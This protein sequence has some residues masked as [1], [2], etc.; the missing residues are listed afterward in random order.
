MQTAAVELGEDTDHA[1]ESAALVREAL[2]KCD[3]PLEQGGLEALTTVENF[4]DVW[5]LPANAARR[6]RFLSLLAGEPETMERVLGLAPREGAAGRVALGLLNRLAQDAAAGPLLLPRLSRVLQE[7]QRAAA[8]QSRLMWLETSGS[9]LQHSSDPLPDDFSVFLGA[10][11][12]AAAAA[13]GAAAAEEEAAVCAEL[14]GL[15][16]AQLLARRGAAGAAERQVLRALAAGRGEWRC[17]RA[18]EGLALLLLEARPRGRSGGPSDEEAAAAR[19]MRAGAER[20]W[21]QCGL[22]LAAVFPGEPA[23]R[24]C[25]AAGR[26]SHCGGC[27]AV[28]YCSAACQKSDWAHHKPECRAKR[29][30]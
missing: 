25:G 10:C 30:P 28:H 21:R 16:A 27:R 4:L 7:T 13:T 6:P 12:A 29:Q 15:L 1:G 24:G 14:A 8:G 18:L 5:H 9:L 26:L 11:L 23:C 2:A 17:E 19:V 22:W 3:L 20:K